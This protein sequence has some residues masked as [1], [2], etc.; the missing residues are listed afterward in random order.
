[1]RQVV[2]ARAPGNEEILEIITM[3][4][5]VTINRLYGEIV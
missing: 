1:M 3:A 4:T 2:K 5:T